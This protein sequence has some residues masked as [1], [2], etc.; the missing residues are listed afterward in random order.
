MSDTKT[1][2]PPRSSFLYANTFAGGS[3]EQDYGYRALRHGEQL[4]NRVLA[5]RGLVHYDDGYAC[6][7]CATTFSYIA[8]GMS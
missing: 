7:W 8:R 2:D 4:A 1:G 5:P 3:A 6:P